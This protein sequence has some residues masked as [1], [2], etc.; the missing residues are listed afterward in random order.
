ML[1]MW[2]I[3]DPRNGKP[4]RTVRFQ[5]VARLLCRMAKRRGAFLDYA[6]KGEGWV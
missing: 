4:I 1:A 3:F 5:F 2:E 6:R